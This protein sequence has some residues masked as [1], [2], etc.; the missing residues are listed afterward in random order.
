[1]GQKIIFIGE[2]LLSFP[3]GAERSIFNELNE[4]SKTNE[5]SAYTFDRFYKEGIVKKSFPVIN[6]GL[7]YELKLSRFISLYYLNYVYI[8]KK[9]KEIKP[10]LKSCDY[11]IIQAMFAPLVADFCIKNKIDYCYYLRDESQLNI[12]NNYESGLRKIIKLFKNLFEYTAIKRYKEM[13]ILALKN[14]KLVIANSRF[15]QKHLIKKFNIN[16]EIRYPP[17]NKRKFRDLKIEKS[18]R[19]YVTFIGGDNAMKGYDIIL[20]ISKKMP[21]TEFLI[22]GDYKKRYQKKNI[23]FLPWQKDVIEIY[24][25]TKILLVPSRWHEAFGRVV[26]E[27]NNLKIPV[28]TSNKGGL[29]EANKDKSL[30]VNDLEDINLWVKKI[31]RILKDG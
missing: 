12:F 13:N 6:F 2:F 23:V 9:L 1:M 29:P 31:Y 26:L 14:A 25:K 22:V 18:R 27:A 20:K 15:M 24:K 21:R 4:L 7:K 8:N 11:V 17:V 30:I 3:G 19:R 5:V 10:Y 28:L 16:S